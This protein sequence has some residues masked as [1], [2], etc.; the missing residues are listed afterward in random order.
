MVIGPRALLCV[1]VLLVLL[2]CLNPARVYS[3]ASLSRSSSPLSFPLSLAHPHPPV[4]RAAPSLL[5]S[6]VQARTANTFLRGC[7][8]VGEINAAERVVSVMQEEWGASPDSSTYEVVVKLLC[9]V[10]LAIGSYTILCSAI[11]PLRNEQFH[12]ET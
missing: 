2:Q 7:V 4:R 6:L 3:L 12:T 5:A 9:Q 8:R 10:R 11:F 1:L